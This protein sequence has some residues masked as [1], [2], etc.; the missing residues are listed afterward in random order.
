MIMLKI[1]LSTCGGKQFAGRSF[2][3][4]CK[5]SNIDT[6]ELSINHRE[7]DAFDIDAFYADAKECGV[8]INSFHLPF[9]PFK[10]VD[11]SAVDEELRI[12]TVDMM[13]SLIEKISLLGTH[14][15]IIHPSAEHFPPEERSDRIEQ[16]KKSLRELADFADKFNSVIA[17]EDLPRTCLG[18]CTAE[19]AELITADDR[20]RVCFD[21]NHLL[22]EG[23]EKFVAEVGEKIIT[24]HISDYDFIDEKHWLPGEGM[25]DWQGLYKALAGVGYQGPWLYE[26]SFG[27]SRKIERERDLNCRDFYINATEIFDDRPLTVIPHSFPISE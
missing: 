6:L 23:Y 19:I 27:S 5:K 20:L 9:M 2:L 8:P 26:V 13:K 7:F 11:P 14:I 21:T 12:S 17:V 10:S 18:N 15:F 3:D 24:T 1:G 4:E 25:L 16:S 22:T